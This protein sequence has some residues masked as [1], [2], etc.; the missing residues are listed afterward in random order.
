M[1]SKLAVVLILMLGLCLA[2]GDALAQAP[3]AACASP[4]ARQFDFWIGEWVVQAGGV[5]TRGGDGKPAGHGRIERS[6]NGCWLQEYWTSAQGGEGTS[7]NSWDAQYGVWRQYWS[8][9][10]GTVLRL[11]GGLRDGSMVMTG[12]LPKP[13]GGDRQQRI[14]WTPNDDGSVTQQWETSG[15]GG[16]EWSTV[17][18]GI[19]RHPPPAGTAVD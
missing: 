15:D 17:F 19:Y 13:G 14:T 16:N 2:R 18:L 8:G 11:Q 5:E 3:A 10:D 9:G 1:T 6:D 7:L 4:Q 12:V